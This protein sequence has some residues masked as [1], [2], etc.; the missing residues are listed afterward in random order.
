MRSK[1]APRQ[2]AG[3]AAKVDNHTPLW[4]RNTCRI[5]RS[6]DFLDR[7]RRDAHIQPFSLLKEGIC[8]KHSVIMAWRNA[9]LALVIIA[10]NSLQEL[11]KHRIGIV[12]EAARR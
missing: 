12:S 6:H 2:E 3:A 8:P 5:K 4:N 7:E 10:D 1:E 9:V 11:S